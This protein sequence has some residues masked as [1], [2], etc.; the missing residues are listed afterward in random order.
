MG[1]DSWYANTLGD[2]EVVAVQDLTGNPIVCLLPGIRGI[3][4][5]ATVAFDYVGFCLDYSLHLLIHRAC[6]NR[7]NLITKKGTMVMITTMNSLH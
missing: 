2:S 7:L 3:D 6:R 1:I 4:Y 5:W